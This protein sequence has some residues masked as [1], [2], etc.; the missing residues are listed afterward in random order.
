MY[1][2]IRSLLPIDPGPLQSFHS[3]RVNWKVKIFIF[4]EQKNIN[5]FPVMNQ[6]H[7]DYLD[8]DIFV[9]LKDS[10]MLLMWFITMKCNS[11]QANEVCQVE[12]IAKDKNF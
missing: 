6:L 3:L 8:K 4:S 7:L 2:N 5:P 1:S 10:T 12:W 11:N 9:F